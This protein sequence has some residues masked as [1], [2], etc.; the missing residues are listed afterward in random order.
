MESP[1][2]RGMELANILS[3]MTQKPR[4]GDF[5]ELKYQKCPMEACPQA[6]LEACAFAAHLGNW[7]VFILDPP[8]PR[9][10]R[11]NIIQGWAG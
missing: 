6:S 11:R 3:L 8:L 9:I 4:N 10:S 7:S 5:R 1:H 2:P